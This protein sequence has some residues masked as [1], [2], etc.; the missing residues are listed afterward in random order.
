[1]ISRNLMWA[2]W[3]KDVCVVQVRCV[4]DNLEKRI[5]LTFESINEEAEKVEEEAWKRFEESA[6]PD[7][8]L[9]SGA[10][11]AFQEGLAHYMNLDNLRQ[12]LHNVSAA[13]CYH[14]F[15][16]QLFYF[17]RKELLKQHEEN[18]HALF[19][20]KEVKKRLA[21]HPIDIEGF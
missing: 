5:L 21:E 2:R 20:H 3:F 17:H 13:F 12:A 15:E 8:D 11:W 14:L 10:E 9:G 16:Q 18:E 4:A 1:M 7:S 6:G 19:T